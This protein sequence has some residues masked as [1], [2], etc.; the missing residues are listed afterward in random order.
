M[1]SVTTFGTRA[2]F[3]GDS[4][5]IRYNGKVVERIILRGAEPEYADAIPLFS[6]ATRKIRYAFR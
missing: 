6:V 2:F 1:E 4:N 5:D 3:F